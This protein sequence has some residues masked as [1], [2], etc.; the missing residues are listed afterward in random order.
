MRLVI[1][2]LAKVDHVELEFNGITIIAGNNDTGKST[3]G[4]ALFAMFTIFKDI[5]ARIKSLR[6]LKISDLVSEFERRFTFFQPEFYG[7]DFAKQIFSGGKALGSVLD[8]MFSFV[9]KENEKPN[10]EEWLRRF[11][12]VLALSEDELRSQVALNVLG[13][14]FH[15]QCV[16]FIRKDT[17]P[18]IQMEVKGKKVCVEMTNAL[19]VCKV[20]I[21]LLHTAYYVDSPDTLSAMADFRSEKI[22]RVTDGRLGSILVQSIWNGYNKPQS[23]DATAFDDL[24][25]RRRFASINEQ[26]TALMGGSV[27]YVKEKGLRF[28][29]NAFPDSPLRL[30]NLS[31]GLKAMALLQVAFMNG[32]IWDDDVLILD[33]PE[34]HLHPEWQI[35]YAEFIVMLQKEFHLTVLLTS[36]SPDF[37]QAIRLYSK[38]HGLK[39]GDLNGYVSKRTKDGMIVFDEVKRDDWDNVFEKFVTSFDA[40]MALRSEL[41]EENAEHGG[42]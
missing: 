28:V 4:K 32:A 12:E 35:R 37:I 33:E 8:E 1:N 7:A 19:P 39:D 13:N 30:D 10:R 22:A 36:H 41:E 17:Y 11:N 6:F 42:E 31:Q 15:R 3:V 18:S 38:K 34:V 20:G 25:R 24:L 21:S 2:N 26:L 9:D 27:V 40:L 14:I 16:S 29:N 5:E 23:A